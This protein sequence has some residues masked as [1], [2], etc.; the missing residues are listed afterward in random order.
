M[1]E[2]PEVETVARTLAPSV[3]GRCI[4]KIDVLWAKSMQGAVEALTPGTHSLL[5]RRIAKVSRR[6]K[7]LLLHLESLSGANDEHDPHLLAFH[8]KMSGQVMVYPNAEPAHKH[9]RLIFEL[10]EDSDAGNSPGKGPPP[11]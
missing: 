9:T 10:I 3:E 1:P 8:L 11:A 7:V 2:L 5:G 4:A 6:A